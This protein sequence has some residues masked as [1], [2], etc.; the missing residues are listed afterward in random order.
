MSRSPGLNLIITFYSII[1]GL[2]LGL[3]IIGLLSFYLHG[4]KLYFTSYFL[5]VIT[6]HTIITK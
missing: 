1:G 4:L 2:L 5:K 6:D 3:T